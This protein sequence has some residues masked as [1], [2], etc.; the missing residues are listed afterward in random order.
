ME[1][2]KGIKKR[3]DDLSILLALFLS[4]FLYIGERNRINQIE[5]AARELP[6]N[7]TQDQ[8]TE[9]S[10]RFNIRDEDQ[11][12][13]AARVGQL[14]EPP[15]DIV[16]AGRAAVI[17]AAFQLEQEA[18]LGQPPREITTEAGVVI[19]LSNGQV[20]ASFERP[21]TLSEEDVKKELEEIGFEKATREKEIASRRRRAALRKKIAGRTE[22]LEPP[23]PPEPTT[24]QKV[25]AG[26]STTFAANSGA[27]C[28]IN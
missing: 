1:F 9:T 18:Q 6:A 23:T 17:E 15:R 20:T 13:V 10:A 7:P 22:E 11:T 16:G 2:F 27:S 14:Q 24:A 19:A 25:T 21:E 26:I 4:P 28:V 12:L 3:I 5:M 8:I